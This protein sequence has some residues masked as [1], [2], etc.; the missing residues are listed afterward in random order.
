MLYDIEILVWA[1]ANIIQRTRQR[2]FIGK[3]GAEEPEITY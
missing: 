2:C 3:V 1:V